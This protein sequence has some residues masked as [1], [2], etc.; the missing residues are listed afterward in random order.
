MGSRQLG[1]QCRQTVGKLSTRGRLGTGMSRPRWSGGPGIGERLWSHQNSK[2][3]RLFDVGHVRGRGN[4][5]GGGKQHIFPGKA[6]ESVITEGKCRGVGN[7]RQGGDSQEQRSSSHKEISGD[8]Q[9][10]GQLQL[11]WWQK[12][13]VKIWEQREY[14]SLLCYST[15]KAGFLGIMAS[16]FCDWLPPQNCT[17]TSDAD[18]EVG[19]DLLESHSPACMGSTDPRM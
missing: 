17:L 15:R 13:L 4:C 8:R 16:S 5:E 10:N 1:L 18:K 12:W 9:T 6:E 3:A 11:W 2:I 14:M 7:L 19:S